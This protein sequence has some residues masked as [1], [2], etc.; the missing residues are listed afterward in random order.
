M[1]NAIKYKLD[2]SKYNPSPPVPVPVPVI[3]DVDAAL[4]EAD[5]KK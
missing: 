5:E 1:I 3:V 2:P 4:R